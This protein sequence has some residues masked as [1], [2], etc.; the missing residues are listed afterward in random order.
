MDEYKRKLLKL[1][2]L[3][4]VLAC[5]VLGAAWT[6]LPAGALFAAPFL[7][8][9]LAVLVLSAIY[10]LLYKY[11]ERPLQLYTIQF[12]SDLLLISLLLF[13]SGGINS[14]F[15]PLYVLLIV[16]ASMLAGRQ[17]GVLALVLS[18]ICYVTIVHLS[19]LGVV[20]GSDEMASYP[21]VVYRISLNLLAFVS[22]AFL[23]IYLSERLQSA[24]QELGAA[25]V[26]HQ[27]IIDSIRSGLLT[28]DLEGRI[29]FF[30]RV[31]SEMLGYQQNALLGRSLSGVFSSQLLERILNSDFHATPRALRMESWMK[32]KGG[33]PLYLGMGCSPLLSREQARIGFILSFQD[34]TEIKKREEE[35]Q[36]RE[37]MAAI[38]E[39]AAGLAHELRNPLGSLS[40]SIQIL[41]SELQ[42]SR[43][44]SKLLEIVLRESERL[45]R[46]VDDFLTF[47]GRKSTPVQPVE[48]APLVQETVQL[49]R[50][51]REFRSQRHFV[52]I[53]PG[54]Q[55]VRCLGN[56]DQ[57]R[58]VVWN[59]L[60]NGIR[61]MPQGG[62]L[63]IELRPL[64]SK[65]LVRFQDEGRG[66]S[67]SEEK[68][69]FQPFH[70]GFKKGAG[71]GMAI[72][73]QIIQQLNG[74]IKVSTTLGKGTQ[75]DV[76]LP[77][78]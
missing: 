55:T 10:F 9:F 17:G 13:F 26:L 3:R 70:T 19:Y 51:S 34:L 7:P 49:F 60:Q 61:A 5:F 77:S 21:S 8:F 69:L 6:T 20:P 64:E 47:A 75:V 40:G 16:Y 52:E 28:L 27:N 46:I 65:A 12:Y 50:N 71:L 48:L 53:T 59:I 45:N 25:R 22:V 78:V 30:N 67:E 68:K 32:K 1:I 33:E 66:M 76:L 44:Q 37:K 43:D 74:E 56:P 58:Q 11:T 35:F 14:L 15:T 41:R 73:Y 72:V 18:I 29:T 36:F 24:R 39:M 54:S 63:F 38:G 57:L 62:R 31:G 23:G 2:V 42:L 4:F